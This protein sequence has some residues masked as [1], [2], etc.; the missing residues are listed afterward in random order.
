MA[1]ALTRCTIKTGPNAGAT[2]YVRIRRDWGRP[3][4]TVDA[5]RTGWHPH[6][7]AARIAAEVNG[8]VYVTNHNGERTMVHESAAK[9]YGPREPMTTTTNMQREG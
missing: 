3:A 8:Y 4:Y 7:K 5:K 1:N 6:T 2:Y 9:Y